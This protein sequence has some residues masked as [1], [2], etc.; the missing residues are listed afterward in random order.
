MTI[1][2]TPNDSIN[3]TLKHCSKNDEILL[4]N[5]IYNEKVLINVDGISLIG[6]SKMV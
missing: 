6:E 4:S 5:G 2:L 1:K 3:E